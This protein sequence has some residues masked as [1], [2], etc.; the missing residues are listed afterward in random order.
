MLIGDRFDWPLAY[1]A[2]KLLRR[3]LKSFLLRHSFARQL[4]RRLR[5]ETATDLFDWI[6]H[7]VLDPARGR[8]RSVH[9]TA[10]AASSLACTK[11]GRM[12]RIGRRWPVA[13]RAGT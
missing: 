9:K 4:D 11:T 7:L 12:P 2:E 6:D 1:E 8:S 5:L 3:R 10:G 13:L